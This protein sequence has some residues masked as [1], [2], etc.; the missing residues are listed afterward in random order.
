MLEIIIFSLLPVFLLSQ[1]TSFDD[2]LLLHPDLVEDEFSPRQSNSTT[3]A[4][5]SS[6]LFGVGAILL[7]SSKITHRVQF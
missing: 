1:E 5:T 3:A 6:L 4:T 7:V 2:E